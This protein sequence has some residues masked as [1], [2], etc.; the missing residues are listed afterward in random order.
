MGQLHTIMHDKC[1]RGKAAVKAFFG[2]P[3]FQCNR[4]TE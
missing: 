1:G 4:I 2:S 3:P